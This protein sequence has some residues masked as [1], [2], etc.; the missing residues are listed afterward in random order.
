MRC[1]IEANAGILYG[2]FLADQFWWSECAL[3]QPLVPLTPDIPRG[4]AKEGIVDPLTARF[5]GELLYCVSVFTYF[6]NFDVLCVSCCRLVLNSP[7]LLTLEPLKIEI[8]ISSFLVYLQLKYRRA[9]VPS[10]F[11]QKKQKICVWILHVLNFLKVVMKS[12]LILHSMTESLVCTLDW[13][14]DSKA[15]C[16]VE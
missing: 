14:S 7:I 11:P 2:L 8:M 9:I 12:N 6:S 16:K 1:C 5:V 15:I 13:K 3:L 4:G 10:P